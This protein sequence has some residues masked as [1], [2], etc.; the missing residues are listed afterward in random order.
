M[1]EC[2]KQTVFVSEKINTEISLTNIRN[3]KTK[4]TFHTNDNFDVS[5]K[6]TN[7]AYDDDD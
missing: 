3:F 5:T 6:L 1:K 2:S 4:L 7:K